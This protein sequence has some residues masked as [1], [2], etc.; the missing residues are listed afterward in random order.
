MASNEDYYA[1][2]ARRLFDEYDAL[3]PR[4]V[5]SGWIDCLPEQTGLVLDVG[6]GSGRDAAWLASKGHT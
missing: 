1:A 2:N 6:A 5:H 4:Q 3:D